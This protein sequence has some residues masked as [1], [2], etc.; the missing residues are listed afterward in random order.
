LFSGHICLVE[1]PE[2]APGIFPED[3]VQV[4]IELVDN[5]TRRLRIGNN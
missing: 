4:Y 1:W 2:K 5:Q 3:T